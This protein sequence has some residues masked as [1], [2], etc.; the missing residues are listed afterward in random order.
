MASHRNSG[1]SNPNLGG[2]H[3]N[4]P[5]H[6]AS[7]RVHHRMLTVIACIVIAVLAF[8]GTAAAAVWI[9]LDSAVK[10][11]KVDYVSQGDGDSEEVVDPNAGE[12]ISFVIIGQ[13]T[14]DGASGSIT[15]DADENSDLHSA[16]TT[17]VAQISADR[18]Y[19]N[20]VSIPRD[21]IV[22]VP[23]CQTTNG[24]V[25]AQYNVMF[26]SIFA[27]AYSVGGN[28]A[29]AATCTVE[30]VNSLTG[31][32]IKNFIVVDFA[33]LSSMVDALG[34]VDICLPTDIEDSNT[35][36]DLK[37][38]LNH[39]DGVTATQYARMRHGT[40]TDGTD[41][42]RTTRQQYLIKTILREAISKNL[43]TQ[44]AQLYQLA[45][46]AIKSLNISSGLADTSTLVGLAM[47]LVNLDTSHIYTQ[48]VP[49]TTW[50]QDAN[51]VVWADSADEVWEKMV[52]GEPLFDTATSVTADE[53]S[54]SASSSASASESASASASS[55]ASSSGDADS[56]KDEGTYDANTGLIV[57]SDGT[58]IDPNTGGMVEAD[59]G[60]II[61][62]DT[63]QYIGI[64]DKYINYKFCGI[65][66]N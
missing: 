20:L 30:A 18:S 7:Y 32:D 65:T 38:G 58:L 39:M 48:T 35:N 36:L 11:T 59:T 53:S 14:R 1:E 19:I 9:N 23:S 21:S 8:A 55:S 57:E 29:S 41:I 10:S 47:S 51:R 24:T 5:R 25:P 46:A 2:T 63:Y 60:S 28:L 13:D 64:A 31:M 6:T 22:S 42:M 50:S 12:T 3:K 62:L 33:G 16:D 37:A 4:P 40:N 45:L 27:R 17:M 15:G 56:K 34:G 66:E 61:D 52:K 44:S 54:P 43:F 26:N 49:V